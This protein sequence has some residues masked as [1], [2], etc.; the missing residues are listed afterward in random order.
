MGYKVASNLG[1]PLFEVSAKTGSNVREAFDE[2]ATQL[3]K[4]ADKE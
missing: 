3:K 2:L 1:A 4:T